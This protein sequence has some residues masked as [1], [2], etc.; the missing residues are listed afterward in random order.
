MS[1]KK[2]TRSAWLKRIFF[3]LLVIAFDIYIFFVPYEGEATS[4]FWLIVIGAIGG[5]LLFRLLDNRPIEAKNPLE[6]DQEKKTNHIIAIVFGCLFFL[7]FFVLSLTPWGNTI[8]LIAVV[9]V[10][11]LIALYY[12]FTRI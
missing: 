1:D 5:Y 7:P 2:A 10:A 9:I 6:E 4:F 12:I 3:I 11:D 8:G